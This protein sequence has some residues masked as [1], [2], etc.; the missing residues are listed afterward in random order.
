MSP[1]QVY[2][3]DETALFWCCLLNKKASSCK[4]V[5]IRQLFARAAQRSDDVPVLDVDDPSPMPSS[6]DVSRTLLYPSDS[7]MSD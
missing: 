7:E 1:E 4:Q 2:N 6:S 3:P 5:D